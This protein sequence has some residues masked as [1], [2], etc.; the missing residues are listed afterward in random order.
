[1]TRTPITLARHAHAPEIIDHLR[2]AAALAEDG[3]WRR[4]LS[5]IADEIAAA[6][7]GCRATGAKAS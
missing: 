5:Q 3:P 2:Y 6:M 4:T 1:M 7:R